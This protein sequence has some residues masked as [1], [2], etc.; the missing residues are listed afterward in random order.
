MRIINIIFCALVFI[1]CGNNKI[2][3]QEKIDIPK[4]MSEKVIIKNL[5]QEINFKYLAIGYF[6]K[7]N[8]L[9]KIERFINNKLQ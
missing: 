9:Q 7:N 8:N 2:N 6:D 4:P 3:V 1:G 5:S